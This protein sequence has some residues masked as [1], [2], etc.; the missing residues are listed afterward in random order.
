MS[1]AAR[2]LVIGGGVLEFIGI[3]AVAWP[4]LLPY[5]ERLSS[6]LGRA[7]RRVAA[8]VDRFRHPRGAIEQ[9]L[10]GLASVGGG[11]VTGRA[12]VDPD[13]PMEEKVEYLLKRDQ[14]VQAMFDSLSAQVV[15][16]DGQAEER[17][18]EVRAELKGHVAT[19]MSRYRALRIGGA[20]ALALGLSCTVAAGFV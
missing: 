10:P 20:V 13:A 15:A 12:F 18:G 11:R 7:Y 17:L 5:G 2:S 1:A 3:M 4:D 16:G 8:W 19:E 6:W 9:V 14:D